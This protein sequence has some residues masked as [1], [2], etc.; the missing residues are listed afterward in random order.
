VFKTD[1]DGNLLTTFGHVG[2]A[3][4]EFNEPSGIT[5]ANNVLLVAD[6][7]N[8]R[9]QVIQLISTADS[10]NNRIQVMELIMYC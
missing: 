6:S 1:F 10:R 2:R 9:I 3:I 8:N 5:K 7:R 4:G